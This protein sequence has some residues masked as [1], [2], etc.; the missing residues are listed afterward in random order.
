[1]ARMRRF[2]F[3]VGL[4]AGLWLSFCA[5]AAGPWAEAGDSGLRSDILLLAS[6]GVIDDVTMQWPLPWG[7]ILARLESPGALDGQP[8]YICDA[9]RR[10]LS[11]GLAETKTHEIRAEVSSDGASEPA[12]VHGFDRLGHSKAEGQAGVE[13]LSDSDALHIAAG[14]R[15]RTAGDRQIYNLDGSYFAKRVGNFAGYVGYR[16]H[17]WGPG[18][19]SAMSLSNNA[20]P[21]AQVGI[22]RVDTAAF[23]SPWLSWIGPWQA[24]MFFGLL[25]GPR[26]AEN[27]AYVGFRF[28]FSPLPHLEIGMA[29]TTEMCGSGHSC[30]PADY[31]G[32]EN[33]NNEINKTNDQGNIDIRYSGA[34]ARFAYEIYVQLMNEDTNPFVHSATSKLGGASLWLPLKGGTER[35]TVEYADSV[36]TKDLWGSGSLYNTAYNNWSYADG[37]RYRGRTLG[38]SLDSDAR[39]VSVQ[40]DFHSDRGRDYALTYHHAEVGT[41]NTTGNIVST[42]P[43]VINQLEA[44]ISLPLHLAEKSVRFEVAGRVQD[45]Q[46]RPH[47]G[48]LASVEASLRIAF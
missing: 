43:V 6:A 44:R 5:A 47:K 30:S 10:V 29:R 41:P 48:E 15:D 28:A 11:E 38:F 31:F 23:E 45:D 13:Y 1:M 12:L 18:W 24:E 32:I 42:G 22:T 37:M 33:Q 8:D 9:A 36:A 27:S 46:P 16:T 26:V 3:A 19:F 7:G 14:A 40:A 20:R 35:I 39:L 2:G 17:W 34:F 25:D 21:M 4:A